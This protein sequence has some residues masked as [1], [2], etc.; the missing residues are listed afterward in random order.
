MDPLKFYRISGL[1]KGIVFR[2]HFDKWVL[3]GIRAI[4]SLTSLF[5]LVFS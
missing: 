2:I 4:N 3:Y 5:K 1:K